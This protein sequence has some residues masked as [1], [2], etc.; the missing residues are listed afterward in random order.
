MRH[1]GAMSDWLPMSVSPDDERALLPGIPAW[2]RRPL[3]SWLHQTLHYTTGGQGTGRVTKTHRRVEIVRTFD[4][5]YRQERALLSESFEDH[6]F[7][8]L[9]AL[10]FNNPHI[11]F[12]FLDYL[13]FEQSDIEYGDPAVVRDLEEILLQ[14]GSEWKV[15]TR[16]G[17]PG[18]ETRVPEG[19]QLAVDAVIETPGHAGQLLAEAWRA[20]FGVHPNA[21]TAYRKAVLAVEAAAIPVVSPNNTGAT[22]GTVFAQMRDQGDWALDITK[23]HPDYPASKV[24]LGMIQMLWKGQGRHAGQTD[25]TPNGQAEAEA[26]VLL[27]VPLVQWFSSGAIARRPGA[28]ADA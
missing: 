6:G 16:L 9:E 23:Q 1:D 3:A 2:M 20:A 19:V 15:G 27:A 13:V 22:L 26:A 17:N 8:R 14:S 25:W 21:E 12:E 10:L 28:G 24:L 11:Y 5:R 18:L 4:Q 7:D